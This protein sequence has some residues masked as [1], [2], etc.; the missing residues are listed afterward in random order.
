MAKIVI[1]CKLPHGLTI[2]H[3]VTKEKVTV[4]GLHASKVIGSTYMTT[5]VDADL[6]AAWK[7]VYSD[8]APL[9]NGAIFEARSATEAKEK[10]ADLVKEKT[11]FEPMPKEVA[12]IKKAEK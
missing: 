7:T 1:G 8:Y 5:E 12:G 4:A 9:K 6:W 10:A 11:G 3:P 2:T